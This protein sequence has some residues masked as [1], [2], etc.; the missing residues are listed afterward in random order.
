MKLPLLLLAGWIT[1]ATPTTAAHY[2]LFL[3]TGQSNSLGTTDGGEADPSPGPDPA[4]AQIRFFWHN[5]ANAKTSLGSSDGGFT[6]L[7]AQ[8]GGFYKGSATHWGPEMAF[9]RSHFRAG[10]TNLGIIKASRGGG[11]N[12]FWSKGGADAHMYEHL[13]KTV[14]AAAAHLQ[15]GGHTFEMAGLLYLQGES[16]SAAEAAMADQR[17]EQLLANLRADLPQAT[18]MRAVIGG[19]A[20]AGATRDVVR[21]KHAGLAARRADI[22]YFDT[23]DLRGQMPDALHFNKAAKLTLGER[24]ARAFAALP[25][26]R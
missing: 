8:Q 19:I 6:K 12:S 10:V 16:D 18:G 5:L 7:Q 21:A 26:L 9:G 25:P 15:A 11:G 23:T 2:Q 3:L 17:F 24:F 1:L 20:A 14:Q 4:D 22:G 13:V